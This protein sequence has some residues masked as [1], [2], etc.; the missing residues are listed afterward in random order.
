MILFVVLKIVIKIINSNGKR[1]GEKIKIIE[2]DGTG[3]MSIPLA[4]LGH[5]VIGVGLKP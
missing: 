1:D 5:T 4:N 2:V 3:L